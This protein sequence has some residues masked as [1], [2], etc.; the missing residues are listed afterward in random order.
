M[1]GQEEP[2]SHLIPRR[3]AGQIGEI[4]QVAGLT[5]PSA[6]NKEASR[7]LVMSR[8][9]L[10]CEEGNLPNHVGFLS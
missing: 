10:L 8:P 5:I 9:P 1:R 4:L 2:R 6:P 7:Y 3:R